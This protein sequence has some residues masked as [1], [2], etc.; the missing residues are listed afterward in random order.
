MLLCHSEELLASSADVS[1]AVDP[2]LAKAASGKLNLRQRRSTRA[3]AR[4]EVP[5]T[6]GKVRGISGGVG[7]D[8]PYEWGG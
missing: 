1:P 2:P 3:A 8:K 4:A 6:S 5:G 7:L